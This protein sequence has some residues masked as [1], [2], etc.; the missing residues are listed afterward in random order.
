MCKESSRL[1][2]KSYQWQYA[3]KKNSKIIQIILCT[4]Y[5]K[6]VWSS[7]CR[8]SYKYICSYAAP[9]SKF[10]FSAGHYG[11]W[12]PV[13]LAVKAGGSYNYCDTCILMVFKN[14]ESSGV[15][16]Y[17]SKCKIIFCQM[18]DWVDIFKSQVKYTGSHGVSH[19]SVLR[20]KR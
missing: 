18:S 12:I 15:V 6:A 16:V 2:Y 8:T 4:I 19:F 14:G 20:R 11:H 17:L 7:K 9:P 1:S 10:W 3:Q 5:I 13:P